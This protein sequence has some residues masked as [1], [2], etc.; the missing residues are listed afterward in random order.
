MP[1]DPRDPA[2]RRDAARTR[3]MSGTTPPRPALPPPLPL[4]HGDLDEQDALELHALKRQIQASSGLFCE[5]YKE[6]CLR[7]RLAVRMRARG[8][9]R[10]A[11]YAALL[12]ADPAEY[13]TLV[14]TVTINVSKF[15]RNPEV[16][17]AVRT[18]VLPDLLER[19]RP[20]RVWSA[21]TATGEEPYTFAML[22]REYLEV[23][24]RIEQAGAVDI[25][26]TDIDAPALEKAQLGIY[27]DLAMVE[28]PAAA[29]ARWFHPGGPPYR[30]R[31][32]IKRMVR[33]T[34]GDLI[35][36]PA[37]AELDLVFCR[38]VFIYF[39]RELQEELLT[40]F[41]DALRP[42]GW[43][44]LGKVET[45]LGPVAR[46]LETVRSRERIYRKR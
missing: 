36:D 32:E 37:P 17:D 24:G 33:F 2:E 14:Q 3:D 35:R 9:H 40:R 27:P 19:G 44:V 25:Q 8:V 30:V 7:R 13:K 31:D 5:G 21:G 10:Y 41:V 29:R 46:R 28:A 6:K 42:K 15:Y 45:L 11:D 23:A 18:V 12:D 34:Q 16:W 38:N 22:V 4:A 20:V 1:S 43:L 26:A 39:E